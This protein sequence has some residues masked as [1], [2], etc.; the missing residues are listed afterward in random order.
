MRSLCKDSGSLIFD[1]SPKA[2]KSCTCGRKVCV[3]NHN[4]SPVDLKDAVACFQILEIKP[5]F[6]IAKQ[7]VID[8]NAEDLHEVER[9][10]DG[11]NFR[12]PIAFAPNLQC[13]SILRTLVWTDSDGCLKQ[14]R[15]DVPLPLPVPLPKAVPTPPSTFASSKRFR[16]RRKRDVKNTEEPQQTQQPVAVKSKFYKLKFA[17]CGQFVAMV[18]RQNDKNE[19][20]EGHWNFTIWHKQLLD[21]EGAQTTSWVQIATLPD[22]YGNFLND[23]DFAFNPRFQTIAVMECAEYASYQT[24][25]WNYGTATEG[26]CTR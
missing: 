8:L 12:F 6:P 18:E 10:A 13:V 4:T 15:I 17:P 25:T 14:Q 21:A 26:L 7:F 9:T 5:G 11:L 19:L 20:P 16:R 2:V 23:G 3:C 22:I 24:S 1:R